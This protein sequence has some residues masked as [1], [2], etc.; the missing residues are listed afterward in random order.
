MQRVA[1]QPQPQRQESK[2]NPLSHIFLLAPPGPACCREPH[3]HHISLASTHAMHLQQ[4]TYYT[5]S[6]VPQAKRHFC[7]RPTHSC[8]GTGTA[9]LLLAPAA[10]VAAANLCTSVAHCILGCLS[11]SP[12]DLQG[13]GGRCW[14]PTGGEG[15]MEHSSRQGPQ[16]ESKS[17]SQ[18]S[19]W[20]L[21]PLLAG[22][23]CE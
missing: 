12:Q 1:K 22:T 18:P 2:P 14:V 8:S 23:C 4:R 11:L 15:E 17:P 10:A 7:H 13:G 5:S 19:E 3:R 9:A 6:A 21:A 20:V 16:R